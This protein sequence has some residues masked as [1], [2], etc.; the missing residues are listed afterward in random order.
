MTFNKLLIIYC[1]YYQF[2]VEAVSDIGS[3][4]NKENDCYAYLEIFA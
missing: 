1:A 3:I 4:I 2:F